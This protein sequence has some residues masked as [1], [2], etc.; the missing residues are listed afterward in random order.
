MADIDYQYIEDMPFR[1]SFPVV[2]TDE[3]YIYYIGGA[4]QGV[5]V[6]AGYSF[7]YSD[8][9]G[10]SI[11]SASGPISNPSRGIYFNGYYWLISSVSFGSPSTVYKSLDCIRWDYVGPLPGATYG[12]YPVRLY[13]N[14]SWCIHNGRVYFT[15]YNNGVN[16][17]TGSNAVLSTVDFVTYT[18]HRY[19]DELTGF[20]KRSNCAFYSIGGVLYVMG[21]IDELGS[22]TNLTDHW[23]SLDDGATWELISSDFDNN[24]LINGYLAVNGTGTGQCTNQQTIDD[25]FYIH[26]Y[27]SFY[28]SDGTTFNQLNTSAFPTTGN[29]YN[30]IK[31][32]NYFYIAG[33]T[34]NTSPYAYDD[35]Y[36]SSAAYYPSTNRMG[37]TIELTRSPSPAYIRVIDTSY[38]ADVTDSYDRVWSFTNSRTSATTYYTTSADYLDVVLEGIYGDTYSISLSAVF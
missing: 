13:Y 27:I 12:G 36:K 26:G 34:K 3:D 33:W 35:F 32:K 14:F 38:L 7:R 18:I 23:R 30:V 21:G 20:P 29:V 6:S 5:Q 31:Y 25:E 15:G 11:L 24:S 2:F 16:Y 37:F 1:K 28:T 17:T 8:I 4:A 22:S 19:H 10:W 9:D